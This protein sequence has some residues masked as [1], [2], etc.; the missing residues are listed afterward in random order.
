FG[1][2][3]SGQGPLG[4]PA[5]GRPGHADAARG[6]RRG[7][8]SAVPVHVVP[9]GVREEPAVLFGR[10]GPERGVVLVH[11]G[12]AG[13]ERADARG[14]DGGAG[15]AGADVLRRRRWGLIIRR[16]TRWMRSGSRS[17]RAATSR[18]SAPGSPVPPRRPS[19]ARRTI[20]RNWPEPG[21]AITCGRR[22]RLGSSATNSS[23]KP[24]IPSGPTSEP[25]LP[26][27]RCTSI[28]YLLACAPNACV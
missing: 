3:G 8:G 6:G 22:R 7:G 14:A 11:D 28:N 26:R 20:S 23:M 25:A 1:G 21:R 4:L 10:L 13:D 27:R 17:T 15:G 18:R 24:P 16:R 9:V 19:L 12:A 5:D 2:A